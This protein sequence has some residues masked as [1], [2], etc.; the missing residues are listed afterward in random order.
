MEKPKNPC[1][2]LGGLDK[3]LSTNKNGNALETQHLDTNNKLLQQFF[4]QHHMSPVCGEDM[5]KSDFVGPLQI[6][7]VL[8]LAYGRKTFPSGITIHVFLPR[9]V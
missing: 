6:V 5:L 3:L 8:P 4:P 2:I 9:G 1:N 7:K